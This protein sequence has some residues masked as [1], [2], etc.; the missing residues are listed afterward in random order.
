ML[1]KSLGKDGGQ[2]SLQQ[3]HLARMSLESATS[4]SEK[5]EKRLL[6]LALKSTGRD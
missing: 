1:L 4:V 5:L 3:P 2:G 6:C